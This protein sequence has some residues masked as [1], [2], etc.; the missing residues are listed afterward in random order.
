M[1][2]GQ[3]KN[4]L[5]SLLWNQFISSALHQMERGAFVFTSEYTQTSLPF[6]RGGMGKEEQEGMDNRF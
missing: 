3:T 2:C 5:W 1:V 4:G 6:Q